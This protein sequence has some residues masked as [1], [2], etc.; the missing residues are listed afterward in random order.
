MLFHYGSDGV[1]FLSPDG[2]IS[3]DHYAVRKLIA[4][5]RRKDVPFTPV[6]AGLLLCKVL[7]HHVVP[8][9]D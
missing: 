3:G 8:A 9:R 7:C 2:F 1:V 6:G 5:F 4:L